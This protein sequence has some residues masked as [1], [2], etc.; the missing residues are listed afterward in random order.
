MIRSFSIAVLVFFLGTNLPGALVSVSRTTAFGDG[1]D[2][3]GFGG[4]PTT[5]FGLS[6]LV[7]TRNQAG[8]ASNNYKDYFR[9]DLFSVVAPTITGA[10][11]T[12]TP[13]TSRASSHTFQIFGLVDALPADLPGGW[14]ETGLNYNNAPGNSSSTTNLGYITSAPGDENGNYVSLLGS[15]TLPS[16]TSG[17][18]FSFSSAALDTFLQSDTTSRVTF[19]LRRTDSNGIVHLASKEEGTPGFAP[20]LSFQAEVIPEP[21]E[22]IVLLTALLVAASLVIPRTRRRAG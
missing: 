22:A 7:T 16:V 9:F 14:S 5:N 1:A 12:F 21:S 8:N 11:L 18:S 10:E 17:T 6:G 2:T 20:T 13:L 19:A 15:V 4:Q 3:Y